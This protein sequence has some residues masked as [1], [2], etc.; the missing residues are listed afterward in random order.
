MK[1]PDEVILTADQAENM[2]IMIEY[3][4]KTVTLMAKNE[5]LFLKRIKVLEE[6]INTLE[7]VIYDDPM[8]S[9]RLLN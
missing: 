6:R 5:M 2:N 4:F 8:D 7:E 3:C 1:K 9:D